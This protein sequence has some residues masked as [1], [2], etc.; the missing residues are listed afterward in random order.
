MAFFD[1][2]LKLIG[3][4]ALLRCEVLDSI[5]ASVSLKNAAIFGFIVHSFNAAL[6]QTK[7]KHLLIELYFLWQHIFHQRV[8]VRQVFGS[9]RYSFL[10]E[11]NVIISFFQRKA[12]FFRKKT[13]TMSCIIWDLNAATNWAVPV[14]LY[15]TQFVFGFSTSSK[16]ADFCLQ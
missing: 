11:E 5:C 9:L 1:T 8:F 12:T 10:Q 14:L 16:E 6:K 13:G 2:S 3:E 15:F 7:R 4:P